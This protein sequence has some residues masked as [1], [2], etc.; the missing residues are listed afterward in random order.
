[1]S[2][3]DVPRC[4]GAEAGNK[5]LVPGTAMSELNSKAVIVKVCNYY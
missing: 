4:C 3:S 1:M 5:E 2:R